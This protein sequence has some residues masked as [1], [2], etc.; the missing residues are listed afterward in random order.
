MRRH[1]AVNRRRP[2]IVVLAVCAVIALGAVS[3]CSSSSTST[4]AT[5]ATQPATAGS[6]SVIVIGALQSP[7]FSA[8]EQ[9]SGVQAAADAI[10]AKGGWDGKTIKVLS[11]NDS[12]NG[13]TAAQCARKAVS[14]HV[15]ADVGALSL[16]DDSIIPILAA[17]GIPVIG[18]FPVTPSDYQ[19][20]DSFP[21]M[22][23]S[24]GE[25]VTSAVLAQSR[26]WKDVTLVTQA[27]AGSS[28][29]STLTEAENMLYPAAGV[30]V[31]HVVAIPVT[32]PDASPYVPQALAP[33]LPVLVGALPNQEQS[34][35]TTVK[36]QGGTKVPLATPGSELTATELAAIN[37][38]ADGVI[39][40]GALPP[41]TSDLPSVVQ[42]RQ[43]MQKYAPGAAVD[44]YSL[45]SWTGMMVAGYEG[46]LHHADT[47][48]SL[49]AA[50]SDIA[51][52]N[53]LWLE[54]YSTDTPNPFPGYP[55]A[56]NNEGYIGSFQGT[57]IVLAAGQPVN[58]SALLA[59][60]AAK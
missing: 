55:R 23:G 15:I 58:Y 54:N 30:T 39:T 14:D 45:N 53:Y 19:S 26:G 12:S 1:R 41:S 25:E 52:L 22:N 29:S 4:T 20:T 49:A 56:F 16:E 59:K 46:N 6:V 34:F 42:F 31:K 36:S 3:A 51:N 27:A 2:G 43:D 44:Q 21:I 32:D 11:C 50:M 8:P 33:G 24:F 28:V 18:Q 48:A 5:T 38:A 9:V 7:T 37:G 47:A 17:A 35:F 60:A 13:N 40:Y 57:E 10:N